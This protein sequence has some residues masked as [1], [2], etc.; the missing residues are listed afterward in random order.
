MMVYTDILSNDEIFT[1]TAKGYNDKAYKGCIVEVPSK[2]VQQGGEEFD[3]GANASAEGGGEILD[4]SVVQVI[5]LVAAHDLKEVGAMGKSVFNSMNKKYF[6]AIKGKIDEIE[7][8]KE[9]KAK[10]DE[11]KTAWPSINKFMKDVKKDMKNYSF[12]TSENGSL[13]ECMPIP[14][15]YPEGASAPIFYFYKIGCRGEKN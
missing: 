3:I 11:F 1:D 15:R 2:M 14:A 8:E 13:G 9:K 5:N 6:K 10:L 7:D 12:F 4:D